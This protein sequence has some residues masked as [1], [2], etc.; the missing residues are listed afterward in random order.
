MRMMCSPSH[1]LA[2]L[3][4]LVFALLSPCAP[5][6]AERPV[7]VTGRVVDAA[8]EPIRG[9]QLAVYDDANHVVDYTRTDRNGEYAVAV[10]R[11]ALHL[12]H[13][14]GPGFIAEVFGTMTRFVGDTIGYVGTPLRA[15]VRAVTSAEADVF[16]DPL[17]KGT[18]AA[19]GAVIDQTLFAL[20]PKRKHGKAPALEARKMPGALL[21]KVIAPQQND[22]VSVARIYWI[23]DEIVRAG[24]REKHTTAAWLD[25]IELT[26]YDSEHTSHVQTDYLTFRAARLEPSLAEPGQAVRI[27]AA[28]PMPPAPNTPIVVV[29]RNNSTGEKWQLEPIGD[30]RYAADITVDRRFPHNDQ[31]IS[32]LA[33]GESEQHPGRRMEAERS[34]EANG[35]W[36]AKKPFV[37]DPLLVASR[38]RADVTLTVVTPRRS[39]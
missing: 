22:L 33:Y 4:V 27:Y 31:V 19:G 8:G 18:I 13:R 32:I 5:C 15:G 24:G 1:R 29:A 9:A 17:T 20:T 30:G 34:L 16:T 23:Q 2:L 6:R 25:P 12:D 35:L 7:W 14:H 11:A 10:P 39:R 26:D 3:L 36:D 21:I 28:L 38:S 37:Y